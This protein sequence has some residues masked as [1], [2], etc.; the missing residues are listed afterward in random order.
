VE[1]LISVVELLAKVERLV[2]DHKR[3]TAELRDLRRFAQ[4]LLNARDQERREVTCWLIENTVQS[5]AAIKM[6]LSM[7]K[8][9]VVTLDPE[10]QRVLGDAVALL[11]LCVSEIETKCAGLYPPLL[12]NLGLAAAMAWHIKRFNEICG[13]R[14]VL[15]VPSDLG[16]LPHEHELA[17]FRIMQESLGSLRRYSARRNAKVHVYRRATE[18]VI[19]VTDAGCTKRSKS[20]I[21]ERVRQLSGRLEIV[22]GP[23][24]ATLRVTLPLT[25]QH[26]GPQLA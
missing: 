6:S 22:S 15:D 5:M 8:D 13:A 21:S 10:M 11:D 23:R 2:A 12:D 1:G 3:G 17:L 26:A 25:R 14:A 7:A 4:Q 19:E 24:C 18:A 9:T 20:E 16:R